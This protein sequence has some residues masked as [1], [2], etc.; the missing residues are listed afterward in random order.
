MKKI[1]C[2]M[3]ALVLVCT[4]LVA[5]GGTVKGPAETTNGAESTAEEDK[6]IPLTGDFGGAEFRI[7][8]AGN[9]EPCNDFNFDEEASS[10]LDA[11]QYKRVLSVES[12]FNVDIVEDIKK[13]YSSASSGKPGPGFTVINTQVASGTPNYDLALIASYDVSQ[14]ATIGYLFDMNSVPG[15]DLSNT[16]WDQNAV[17][18]LGVRDVLFFTTGEITVSDNNCAYCI[19]FN[20]KLAEDYQIE[21]PY[22]LVNSG[23]WTIEKFTELAK[24][25]SEDLN[26]DGVYDG[27]DRYGL[28]VW[29][30]SITGIINAAGQRCCTINE[31]GK[32]ELTLYNETTLDAL[33][34]YTELAYDSQYALQYQRLNNS[35]KG[36]QWWQNNQGLFFTALVG[37]MPEYREM[38]NDFG[39]L[40]YPKLTEVQENHYTTISPYNSQFICIPVVNSNIQQTGILTEALGYYG[41]KDITPALYDVT[42]K[43]QSAR[44]SESSEMLDIIFDNLIYDIGYYYQIGP[45]NKQLIIYLRDRNNA[46]A[47]MYETYSS[48][49]QS[50]L[51]TINKAY[52]SAVALWK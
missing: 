24:K 5:C 22:E 6:S 34:Q 38:E 19:M 41:E 27:N 9:G 47:S 31:D 40:P 25:V 13:G 11:A 50:S 29:D 10:T 1:I 17:N 39:I 51:D 48:A 46:W 45:Y 33:N 8:T 44:D 3:L 23:K 2:L 14:L 15:I 52:D 21:D 12:A 35:G 30:D 28:L 4:A 32:I 37:E 42:L 43:G 20:K 49:A 16:W 36:S 7:L 26:Q 18:S